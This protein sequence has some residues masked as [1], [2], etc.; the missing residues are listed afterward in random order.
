LSDEIHPVVVLQ[1]SL[2]LRLTL[3]KMGMALAKLAEED[4][5]LQLEQ[6]R[7]QGK[8]LSLQVWVSFT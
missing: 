5:R 8:L 3:D 2:K 4:Q 7:L 6:M 1:L